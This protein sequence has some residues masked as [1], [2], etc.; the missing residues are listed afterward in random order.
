MHFVQQSHAFTAIVV[1]YAAL[2]NAS[3]SL[4]AM[5][6]QVMPCLQPVL[7]L[8]CNALLSLGF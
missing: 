3:S 1:V 7:N 5:L 6:C 2:H 4:L 8:T